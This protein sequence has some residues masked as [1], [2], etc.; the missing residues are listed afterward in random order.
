MVTRTL[1]PRLKKQNREF[2]DFLLLH[3]VELWWVGTTKKRAGDYAS[4]WRP[5]PLC[6]LHILLRLHTHAPYRTRRCQS[7]KCAVSD[8]VRL[9]EFWFKF[10]LCRVRQPSTPP[11]PVLLLLK[12]PHVL[13]SAVESKQ[14]KQTTVFC[15]GWGEAG[16]G[17]Q[18]KQHSP[19][20]PPSRRRLSCFLC[21]SVEEEEKGGEGHFHING[22]KGK[23]FALDS[24]EPA[25]PGV[26][27]ERLKSER[28]WNITCQGP[29]EQCSHNRACVIC[30]PH[31]QPEVAPTRSWAN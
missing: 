27:G 29:R 10:P 14:H 6:S 20:P 4:H 9:Q 17:S 22:F 13:A 21:V 2:W 8:R 3:L 5:P 7:V 31:P 19:Q 11:P 16:E 24:S 25:W 1:A 15:S 12:H 26:R 18:G 28:L 23:V 30:S